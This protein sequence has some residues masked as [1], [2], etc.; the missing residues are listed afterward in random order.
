VIDDGFDFRNP[1]YVQIFNRRIKFLKNIRAEPSSVPIL[2]A[3]YRENVAQFITDW[4]CT[5]DPRNVERGLPAVVP[6]ILFP[7]QREWIDY[8]I[9]KWKAQEPGLTEKSRDMGVSWLAV[10][11]SCALCLF[12]RGM[13]I[14]FGS[15]KEE[16]VDKIGA[17]KSLFYKARFFMA[18]L[19]VEFRGG[20]ISERDAP[21]LRL[22]FPETESNISGEAG[23]NI[24][25]GD[26][27][28]IYFV[29]EAAYLEHPDLIEA[30]LS[31]TTNCRQDL[32]SPNGSANAFSVKRHGGK[33]EVFTF[34]WR[35]DPRKDDVWYRK[36]QD[37]LDP[38]VVAQEIDID[39][40]A[41]TEGVVIPANW[42]R[43]ALDAHIKLGF[44]PSG[45]RTLSLDIAD[46]GRDKNGLIGAHGVV[47]DK[48]DEWSGKGSDTF[49]TV[50][51]VFDACDR[52]EY[53]GFRYDSDGMGALVRGDA[54]VLNEKRDRYH[55][56]EVVAFR[57][58]GGVF[59]PEYEDV[60]GRKNIDYF[61]NYKAQGWW[62]LR[63]RFMATYRAVVEK[64]PCKPDDIIS[65]SS[66]CPLAQKLIT[67]LSQ[68]TCTFNTVGKIVID[69]APDG[70]PSPNLADCC[71]MQFAPMRPPL[72]FTTATVA[73]AREPRR[74]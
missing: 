27:T 38:V 71:M 45:A 36:Q 56:I 61:A 43:A 4:G 6:F 54:R 34:H 49:A 69:K 16:Y 5:L 41:S 57:G 60:K 9:R 42:A 11:T 21:H 32:G 58:S 64:M 26:R 48:I 35:D 25:R 47:I 23:D 7:R 15:R 70:L 66:A 65:I 19:P 68:P 73:K 52:E 50:Q 31:Q 20:W 74:A 3:Y 30:S 51:R 13:A 14:G 12:Y 8:V 28:G 39:Y 24:G 44:M 18:N 1:D 29:D 46:E 2:K 62:A 17:P 40:A 22:N 33:I 59:R 10:S 72:V 67:E 53:T 55:K 63:R 37:L